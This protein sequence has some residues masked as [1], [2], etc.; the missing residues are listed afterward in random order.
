MEN[1]CKKCGSEEWKLA[2]F[3]YNSGYSD[4]ELKNT[5][6]SNVRRGLGHET[7]SFQGE[8][9]GIAKSKL[10]EMCAPPAKVSE[11]DSFE[12][13]EEYAKKTKY[14]QWFINILFLAS[15]FD[16]R[17]TWSQIL[18]LLI[19]FICSNVYFLYKKSSEAYL[20]KRSV[21]DRAAADYTRSLEDYEL[22]QRKK[23][24]LRCGTIDIIDNNT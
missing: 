21:H 16:S 19:L 2:S 13:F 17:T 18:L 11:P 10:A 20:I 8:S 15:A 23:V 6:E 22:W 3:I 1:N 12:S 14:I 7:T 5:G 24:C 4:I 9:K